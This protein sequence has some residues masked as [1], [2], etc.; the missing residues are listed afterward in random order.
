MDESLFLVPAPDTAGEAVDSFC[1][2][3]VRV[4]E[5]DHVDLFTNK[6]TVFRSTPAAAAA[7]AA[8]DGAS[9]QWTAA[10]VNP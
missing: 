6:R 8:S 3:V 7:T 1:L 4:T 2:G 10:E 9:L 5:V